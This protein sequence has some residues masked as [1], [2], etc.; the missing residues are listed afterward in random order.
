VAIPLYHLWLK[1]LYC[2]R[3]HVLLAEMQRHISEA[4]GF[5]DTEASG[6]LLGMERVK[7]NILDT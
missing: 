1:I 3:E 5:G 6:T 7:G 4:T 2:G